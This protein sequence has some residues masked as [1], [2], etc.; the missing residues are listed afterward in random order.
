[1]R[2]EKSWTLYLKE[3]IF[4]NLLRANLACLQPLL[5]FPLDLSACLLAWQPL[6]GQLW[7]EC[8]G[9]KRL[10]ALSWPINCIPLGNI[11]LT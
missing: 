5:P 3:D 9:R 1:M 8:V 2:G 11:K 10:P 7:R 6:V 4:A